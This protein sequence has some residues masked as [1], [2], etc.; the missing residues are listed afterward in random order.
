MSDDANK[1]VVQRA[2]LDGMNGKDPAV[3]EECFAADYVCHFPAD[4]GEVRGIVD[5]KATLLDFLNA[6]DNLV[7]TVEQLLADG[8]RVVLRWS[9]RGKHTGDY[10]GLPPTRVIPATGKEISMSATDIYRVV[11]GRIVEE[12]NTFDGYH[13][14]HQMGALTIHGDEPTS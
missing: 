7:F 2:Y 13:V 4:Q 1:R 5:F 8:D 12:W 6:F 9:A 3:I 14:L 10:K 11:D